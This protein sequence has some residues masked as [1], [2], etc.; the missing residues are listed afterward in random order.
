M[1]YCCRDE[2]PEASV[3][4]WVILSR[5]KA[6]KIHR[7]NKW[8]TKT[9]PRKMWPQLRNP[10]YKGTNTKNFGCLSFFFF[11]KANSSLGVSSVMEALQALCWDYLKV[12]SLQAR[13]MIF[14]FPHSIVCLGPSE[15]A[16]G[17]HSSQLCPWRP[18][19]PQKQEMV[20]VL[21]CPP[22]ICFPISLTLNEQKTEKKQMCNNI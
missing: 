20:I 12:V 9:F 8:E 10:I 11:F 1:L 15:A 5:S 22:S 7:V 2:M 18:L 3:L 17:Q 14:L 16:G 13:S 4:R 6:K 19:A 21:H